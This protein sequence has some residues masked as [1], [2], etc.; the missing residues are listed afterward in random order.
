MEGESNGILLLLFVG[1][2]LGKWVFELTERVHH[3]PALHCQLFLIIVT[4]L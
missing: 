3:L 2:L 1:W 4:K